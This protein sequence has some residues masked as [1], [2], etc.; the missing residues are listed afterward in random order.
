MERIKVRIRVYEERVM[1]EGLVG[2]GLG[3]WRK[4]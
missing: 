1:G 4:G 2:F 3:I